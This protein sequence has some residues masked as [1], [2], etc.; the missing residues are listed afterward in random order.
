[1]YK[2][3]VAVSWAS[4]H[5]FILLDLYIVRCVSFGFFF[6]PMLA[7]VDTKLQFISPNFT[8]GHKG[9]VVETESGDPVDLKKLGLACDSCGLF[10]RGSV[11]TCQGRGPHFACLTCAN[12]IHLQQQMKQIDGKPLAIIKFLN[13]KFLCCCESRQTVC[14]RSLLCRPVNDS[15]AKTF[16]PPAESKNYLFGEL[17]LR[18]KCSD[19]NFCDRDRAQTGC[20]EVFASL[21]EL[22]QHQST[23]P[24][25]YVACHCSEVFVTAE[26]LASH[27]KTCVVDLTIS[28]ADLAMKTMEDRMRREDEYGRYMETRNEEEQRKT[29]QEME[30]EKAEFLK[31]G[32]T[33]EEFLLLRT[34]RFIQSMYLVSRLPLLWWYCLALSSMKILLLLANSRDV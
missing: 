31:S 4:Y 26:L 15:Y 27:R 19:N 5:N 22:H 2:S 23:C 17:R 7:S 6:F 32:L 1:M 30:L 8:L 18:V 33:L 9:Y 12:S 25:V 29:V 24:F 13:M 10:P 34:P 14:K 16:D 21:A 20:P 3:Q 28:P 11:Q